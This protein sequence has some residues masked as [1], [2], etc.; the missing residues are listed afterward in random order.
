MMTREQA[1]ILRSQEAV[2]LEKLLERI[3]G[4]DVSK[5]TK[6]ELLMSVKELVHG[7]VES[8]DRGVRQEYSTI[9]S[10]GTRYLTPIGEKKAFGVGTVTKELRREI[11]LACFAEAL[12]R[13]AWT[14]TQISQ[15]ILNF[16]ES[17]NREESDV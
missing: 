3:A 12:N 13:I 4:V 14:R 11:G 16:E 5:E 7:I 10:C 9:Y 8:A 1:Y 2:R 6:E 17:H 15:A